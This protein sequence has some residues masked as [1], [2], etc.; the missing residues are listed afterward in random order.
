MMSGMKPC[1]CSSDPVCSSR[2]PASTTVSTN[3][4]TTRWRPNSCMMIMVD[5]GPPPRPPTSSE[6]GAANRPSSA[7]AFHCLR[8]KPSSLATILRRGVAVVRPRHE[9]IGADRMLTDRQAIVAD[10]AVGQLGDVLEYLGAADLEQRR[11]RS[12]IDAARHLRH[13]PQLGRLERQHVELDAGNVPDEFE[14]GGIV[15]WNLG[16]HDPFQPVDVTGRTADAGHAGALVAEQEFGV[17]PSPVLLADQVFDGDP[18]VFQED[19]IDLMGA[20]DGDDRAHGDAR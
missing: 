20:V 1:F 6:N 2:P 13:D 18:D 9:M 5:S 14:M 12:R 7:N 16:L 4:S 3:G 17:S 8:L 15:G 11:R 19:V 10:G